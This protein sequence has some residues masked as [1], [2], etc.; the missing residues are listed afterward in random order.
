MS[1]FNKCLIGDI[2]VTHKIFFSPTIK[3]HH[4]L[5]YTLIILPYYIF[6][7]IVRK[8]NNIIKATQPLE[9]VKIHS[10]LAKKETN[11]SQ[12]TMDKFHNR[13]I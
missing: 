4:N 5:S 2:H 13:G 9:V 8:I 1:Y 6:S 7:S 11:F 3:T 10:F 12:L